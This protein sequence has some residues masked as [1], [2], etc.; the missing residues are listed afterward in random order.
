MIINSLGF[1]EVIYTSITP[2]TFTGV[3]VIAW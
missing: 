1:S 3:I 2:G